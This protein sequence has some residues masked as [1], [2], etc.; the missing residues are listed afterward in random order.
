MA[1][2]PP[3]DYRSGGTAVILV[4]ARNRS[5][6]GDD[7]CVRDEEQPIPVNRA[8]SVG[9]RIVWKE[10]FGDSRFAT[11]ASWRSDFLA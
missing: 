6:D 8:G 11:V 5:I 10:S 1:D 4:V 2:G 9:I 3:M 7:P